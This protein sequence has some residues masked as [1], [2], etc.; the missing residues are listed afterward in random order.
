MTYSKQEAADFAGITLEE[1]ERL[2]LMGKGPKRQ[3]KGRF[4]KAS[5]TIWLDRRLAQMGSPP[6]VLVVEDLEEEG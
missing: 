5:L 2:C 1:M 6:G 4:P 3:R